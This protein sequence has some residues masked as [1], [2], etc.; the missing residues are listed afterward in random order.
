M[1]APTSLPMPRFHPFVGLDVPWLLRERARTCGDRTYLIWD[2]F[3]GEACSYSYAEFALR[4]R[5]LR[6]GTCIARSAQGGFL[7]HTS[8]QLRRVP[9]RV[10]CLFASRCRGGHHEHAVVVRRAELLRRK[11]RRRR[12][13]DSASA[14]VDV[15]A[16]SASALRFIGDDGERPGCPGRRVSHGRGPAISLASMATLPICRLRPLMIRWTSTAF[17]TPPAPRRGRKA[18]SGL[19]PTCCG[20]RA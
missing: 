20:A 13:L 12:R 11:L 18:L 16:A 17:N 8:R 14:L 10:A 2:P 9:D 15:V 4:V 19:T 6:S 7:P 1:P 5:P 3:E